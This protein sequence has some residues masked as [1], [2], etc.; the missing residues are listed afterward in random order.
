MSTTQF[1]SEPDFEPLDL[2]RA[3]HSARE[4]YRRRMARRE[5]RIL[6]DHPRLAPLRHVIGP[7]QA[8][9]AWEQGAKGEVKVG[10]RLDAIASPDCVVLHD[11]RIPRSRANIDH[12]V[13]T[14]KQVWVVDTKRYKG[15]PQKRVEGGFGRP[16]I[17]LLHVGGR[18]RTPLVEGVHKQVDLVRA[19]LTAAGHEVPVVG[20]LAFVDADWGSFQS[21]FNVNDVH[22][23]W[24]RAVANTLRKERQGP[25]DVGAVVRLLAS[26]FP[27]A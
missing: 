21:P 3:G 16:K 1:P 14:R 6:A 15:R 5:E 26:H 10:R 12:M 19:V 22:V 9:R 4:E 8:T 18:N 20:C 17:E 27:P 11:R 13:V 23:A 7:A 2:G 24:P 25:V